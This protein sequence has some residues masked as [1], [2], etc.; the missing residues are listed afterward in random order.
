MPMATSVASA[1]PPTP[2]PA[3][4]RAATRGTSSPRQLSATPSRTSPA[5]PNAAG[6]RRLELE[7]LEQRL[8]AE[9]RE[10]PGG[11]RHERGEPARVGPPQ[12]RAARA[13]RA[14]PARRRRGARSARS[15]GSR[16]RRGRGV[17]TAAAISCTVSMPVELVTPTEIGSSSTQS[18]GTTIV[19]ERSRPSVAGPSSVNG[20]IA[21]S[22]VTERD[23]QLARAAGCARGS[24]ISPG[25]TRRG[26]RRTRRPAAGCCPTG[27][28]ASRRARRRASTTSASS[29]IGTSAHSRQASPAASSAPRLHQLSTTSK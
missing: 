21:S 6:Q 28:R 14:R 15:R 23:R 22:T 9:E 12:R 1:R 17:S 5:P 18:Y 10:Q 4:A 2:A 11:E 27:R 25:R 16:A 13:G 7:R 3:A 24:R 8:D 29:T 20:T 26:A 19:L